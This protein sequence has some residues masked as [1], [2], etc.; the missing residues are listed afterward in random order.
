MPFSG[1]L[2]VR[3]GSR[4]LTAAMGIIFCLVVPILP[5]FTNLW[6]ISALFFLIGVLSGSMDVSMNGQAVYVERMY[7]KPL[8][9]SFHAVFSI[10]MALGA[11]MGALFA[12]LQIELF[13]HFLTSAILCLILVLWAAFNLVN[14]SSNEAATADGK[15]GFRLPTKAILPLG[16]IAFC[17]MTGEGSMADWSA[18]YMN[19]VVGKDE[20]FSALA[21]GSFSVAMTLGRIF[22]DYFTAK[23]GR[24]QMLVYNSLAAITGLS[25]MLFFPQPYIVLAAL[26][27]IGL[28]LA[29]VVP[30]IY[31]AAGNTPGVAP[32]VGIAMAT[33]VGYAGFF[34][35]PPVIGY[36][37]DAFSLRIGLTFSLLL[38]VVMLILVR[39]ARI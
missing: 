31:S 14:E 2:T 36:L 35:G 34:V 17:G 10:G 7:D 5:L 16:I 3:F 23:V 21:F 26:F 15:T 27:L 1:L 25:L 12:K 38:F 39:R 9:S 18:I 8:M 37:A 24:K 32:S 30:I 20:A 28:G 11:G 4:I 6:I 33:T 19:K 29:T 13:P 22:G